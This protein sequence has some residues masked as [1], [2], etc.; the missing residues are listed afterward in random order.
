[1]AQGPASAVLVVNA[2]S[3]SVKLAL[4]G[5]QG[6]TLQQQDVD[7]PPDGAEATDALSAF[8]GKAGRPAAVGHRI[9]HG[10]RDLHQHTL[11]D[12]SVVRRLEGAAD[13]APLHVPPALA[14]IATTRSLLP[15]APQVACLDTVFHRDMP[16]QDLRPLPS[17]IPIQA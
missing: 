4:I 3:H 14:A 12:D 11:L 17:S 1:M 6:E 16:S 8:V 7:G 5:P 9:V 13:I 10:G 15:D 2:G